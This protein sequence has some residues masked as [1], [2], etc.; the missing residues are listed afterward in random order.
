MASF[1]VILTSLSTFIWGIRD[2]IKNEFDRFFTLY[3]KNLVKWLKVCVMSH[4]TLRRGGRVVEGARLEIVYTATYRGFES[5][6]LRHIFYRELFSGLFV[7]ASEEFKTP[8]IAGFSRFASSVR[9]VPNFLQFSH[10]TPKISI[11]TL[12]ISGTCEHSG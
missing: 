4:Q 10:F 3:N 9:C 5:L 11:V 1:N 8:V 12:S 2:F 6:S 7:L